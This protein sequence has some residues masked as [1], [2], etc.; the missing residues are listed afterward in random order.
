MTVVKSQTPR[1]Y[2]FSSDLRKFSWKSKIRTKFVVVSFDNQK[3]YHQM[4]LNSYQHQATIIL[5]NSGPENITETEKDFV[6]DVF[7]YK[8]LN[9]KPSSIGNLVSGQILTKY[10]PKCKSVDP[11]I[12][13]RIPSQVHEKPCENCFIG[14]W[15]KNSDYNLKFTIYQNH[16]HL[17]KT[18]IHSFVE[19]AHFPK[20]L[21]RCFLLRK[22]KLHFWLSSYAV[23]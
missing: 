5:L 22:N 18:S 16:G 13:P 4:K 15:E 14:K 7:L 6:V 23:L 1:L 8:F 9:K 3:I 19:N 2:S 11:V 12:L 10:C 21:L 17:P 20:N